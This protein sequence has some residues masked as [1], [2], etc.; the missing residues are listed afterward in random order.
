MNKENLRLSETA[1][2][3]GRCPRSQ[4]FHAFVTFLLV[5]IFRDR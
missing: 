3:D 2:T 1:L 5:E 4:T